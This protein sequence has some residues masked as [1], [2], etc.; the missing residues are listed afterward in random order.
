MTRRSLVPLVLAL[1]LSL[2]TPL[3]AGGKKGVGGSNPQ[4]PAPSPA[5]YCTN[6]DGSFGLFWTAVTTTC[7]DAPP[8]M[9]AIQIV[10]N[11]DTNLDSCASVTS[12]N[13]FN[14]TVPGNQTTFTTPIVR[15]D[16]TC[17][18]TILIKAI[19]PP[20]KS[21]NNPQALATNCG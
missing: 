21:Q 2:S 13:V 15:D 20:G 3:L 9:Y 7:C 4:F 10:V 6:G 14:F 17:D 18:W 19:N 5:T 8:K 12:T 16:F 1:T 11:E